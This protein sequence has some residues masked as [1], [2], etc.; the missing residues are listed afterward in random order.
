MSDLE[1]LQPAGKEDTIVY[2]PYYSKDKHKILPLAMS[3]YKEGSLEGE[4][5]IEA[6]ENIPFVATWYVSSLPSELT[7]FQLIFSSKAD[8]SYNMNISNADLIKY[9]I[10]LIETFQKSQFVDFSNKFYRKLLQVE[11]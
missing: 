3:L 5:Q 2:V 8:L 6:S 1:N 10:E 7:S 9:L 4:R 11:D